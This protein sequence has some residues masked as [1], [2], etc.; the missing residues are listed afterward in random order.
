M[1]PGDLVD[2]REKTRNCRCG[3]SSDAAPMYSWK[4]NRWTLNDTPLSEIAALLHDTY[5]VTVTIETDS[6]KKQVVNGIV[7]TDNMDDLLN[8]LES[9]LPITITHS[10]EPGDDPGPA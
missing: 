10:G 2:F 9:V 7:P 5:G 1:K 3:T 8:A 6:L 4:N